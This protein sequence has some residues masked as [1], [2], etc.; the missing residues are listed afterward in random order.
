MSY[1]LFIQLEEAIGV[2][3]MIEMC[4]YYLWKNELKMNDVTSDSARC[5]VCDSD[6]CSEWQPCTLFTCKSKER[7]IRPQPLTIPPLSEKS[8]IE[9]WEGYIGTSLDSTVLSSIAHSSDCP[10]A[11]PNTRQN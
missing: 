9:R 2:D 1:S 5:A 3:K 4:T 6:F 7:L 10:E 8:M 11:P